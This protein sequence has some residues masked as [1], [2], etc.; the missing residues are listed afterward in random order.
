M[1]ANNCFG[2]LGAVC[3]YHKQIP[4]SKDLN[5]QIISLSLKRRRTENHFKTYNVL[6]GVLT[7]SFRSYSDQFDCAVYTSGTTRDSLSNG[8]YPY[9]RACSL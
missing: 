1:L 3:Y 4:I 5:A 9:A 2:Y 6:S 7:R 8:W